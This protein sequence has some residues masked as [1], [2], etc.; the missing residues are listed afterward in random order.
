LSYVSGDPTT[1]NNTTGNFTFS[2]LAP[3]TYIIRVMRPTG[4]TQTTPTNN[5]GQHITITAGQTATGVLFGE[6]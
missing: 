2:D 5:F 1:T 3:G 6:K 4:W